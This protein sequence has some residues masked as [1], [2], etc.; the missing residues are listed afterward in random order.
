MIITVSLASTYYFLEITF[1]K[2]KNGKTRLGMAE[3][4]Q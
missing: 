2:K 1:Y 3:M 4:M